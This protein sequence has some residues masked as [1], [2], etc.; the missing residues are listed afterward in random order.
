MFNLIVVDGEGGANFN[1]CRKSPGKSQC[2]STVTL[3][4]G[5]I[6]TVI[7]YF[8]LLAL[9][10]LGLDWLVARFQVFPFK[11]KVLLFL[12]WLIVFFQ[13]AACLC[14]VTRCNFQQFLKMNLKKKTFLLVKPA[15]LRRHWMVCGTLPLCDYKA[16][17][18]VTQ[19]PKF[20][21]ATANIVPP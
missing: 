6:L 7:C 3:I 2:I 16:V 9:I 8:Q 14:S 18:W 5:A 13:T 20:T 19:S 10:H 17:L 15:R 11:H 4:S 21:P 12:T 1:H